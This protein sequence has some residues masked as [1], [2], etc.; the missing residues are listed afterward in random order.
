MRFA[1]AAL[2]GAISIIDLIEGRRGSR[3]PPSSGS[4]SSPPTYTVTR[5][6]CDGFEVE[7]VFRRRLF[8]LL[9]DT[10]LSQVVS[11]TNAGD[12]RVWSHWFNVYDSDAYSL[13]LNDGYDCSGY[14]GVSL[15]N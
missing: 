2:M 5:A 11:G 3:A 15:S 8:E 12:I 4:A 10:R 7:E 9:G 6:I 13:Y 1:T 14:D